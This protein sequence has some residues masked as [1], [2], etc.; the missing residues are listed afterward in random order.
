MIRNF[1]EH[2]TNE[3]TFLSWVRTSIAVI[4]FGFLVER[5]DLFIAFAQM[6][7]G[8][9]GIAI[10]RGEFGQLAGLVL[11]VLGMVMILVAALRF[12]RNAREIDADKVFAGTGSR[13]DLALAFLIVLLAGALLFYLGST[14]SV[15]A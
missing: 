1:S 9:N 4:A 8:K 12:A 10:P 11:I 15:K 7:I 13:V 14:L 5:F 3:R 6:E 2:A